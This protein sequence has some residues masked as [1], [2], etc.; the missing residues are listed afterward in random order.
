MC[1]HAFKISKAKPSPM[2]L[3]PIAN[4]FVSLCALV[5]FALKTSWTKA[6]RIP[7]TLLAVIET[8]IPVPHTTTPL[9]QSPDATAF[10]ALAAKSG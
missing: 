4:I 6:Q 8:P 9:S 2:T 1:N 5:A 7:L 10:A 3:C